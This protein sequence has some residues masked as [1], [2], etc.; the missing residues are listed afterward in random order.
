MDWA[1]FFRTN[2]LTKIEKKRKT[3]KIIF[4]HDLY[5][6]SAPDKHKDYKMKGY[7]QV[8]KRIY[9]EVVERGTASDN[10]IPSTLKVQPRILCVA[11]NGTSLEPHA[12]LYLLSIH[13]T[14]VGIL[15]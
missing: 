13:V 4:C 1:I 12:S 2:K 15:T 14:R 10:I 11:F 5:K 6:S 3:I 7:A 8:V 9:T